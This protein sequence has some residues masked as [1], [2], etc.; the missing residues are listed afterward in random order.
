M[1]TVTDEGLDTDTWLSPAET[2]MCAVMA[3]INRH[4]SD[5]NARKMTAATQKSHFQHQKRG[6]NTRTDDAKH[7]EHRKRYGVAP[8]DSLE[9]AFTT[10]Q[11]PHSA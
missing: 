8:T 1:H 3:G 4:G 2:A 5:T 6:K 10:V 9:A 7:S 11:T